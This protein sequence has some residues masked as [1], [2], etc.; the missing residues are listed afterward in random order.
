MQPPLLSDEALMRVY[1]LARRDGM[2]VLIIASI[3]S[4]FAAMMGDMGGAMIGVTVAGAGAL[5]LQGCHLLREGEPRGVRWLI[6]SQ[7]ALMSVILIYCLLRLLNFQP[8]LVEQAITPQMR[9]VFTE[10]GYTTEMIKKLIEKIYYL[11][12]SLVG[13]ITIIYQGM[14]VRHY[15]LR[16]EAITQACTEE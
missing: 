5:E 10:A 7:L 15:Y 14:M 12:Y 4:L 11:T 8:E 13:I 6:T 16:R 1:R 2:S 3:F 9:E